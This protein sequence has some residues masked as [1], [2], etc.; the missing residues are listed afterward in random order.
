MIVDDEI[1]SALTKLVNLN[2]RIVKI[3]GKSQIL[4]IFENLEILN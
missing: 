2:T 1:K 4:R 3:G